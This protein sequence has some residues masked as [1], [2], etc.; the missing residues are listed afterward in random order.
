MARLVLSLSF[1]MLLR[2]SAYYAQCDPNIC[3][4]LDYYHSLI[5]PCFSD[6]DE[7]RCKTIY[8]CATIGSDLASF[9]IVNI[10]SD[11]RK[12]IREL[13]KVEDL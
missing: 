8:D 1:I 13:F 2:L 4:V 3:S 10:T 5:S 9:F 6:S 7:D 11:E 12:V